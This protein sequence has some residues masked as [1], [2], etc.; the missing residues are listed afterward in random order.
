[1]ASPLDMSL[2]GLIAQSRAQ[3]RGSGARGRGGS[4]GTGRG[5]ASTRPANVRCDPTDAEPATP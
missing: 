2:D 4:R 3:R 5:G 1:M